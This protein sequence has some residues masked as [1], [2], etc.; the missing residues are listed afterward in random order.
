MRSDHLAKHQRTHIRKAG[1]AGKG[2]QGGG[3]ASGA[4]DLQE[5]IPEDYEEVGDDRGDVMVQEAVMVKDTV[6]VVQ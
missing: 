5:G 4:V 3:D 6:Y 2:Q 1:N